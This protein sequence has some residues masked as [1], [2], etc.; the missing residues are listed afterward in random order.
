MKRWLM[1]MIVLAVGAGLVQAETWDGRWGLGLEAGVWKQIHGDHDYSNVDQYT[2]LKLRY[3]LDA[4]WTLDMGLQYGWTRP[5]VAIA[6]EDAGFSFDSGAGLYTRIWQPNLTGTYRL[7]TDGTW[8]PWVS[9]GAGVTRWDIRDLRGEESVGLWPDGV[10]RRV[11]DEDGVQVDGSGVNVTAILGLGTEIAA[12]HR[13]FDLGVRYNYLLGQTTDSVGLSSF[14]GADEVDANK[15]ILQGLVGVNYVFGN[16][17]KDGDG[18]PNDVDADPDHAEDF[19][20]YR[21]EDG[22]PDYDNDNDGILDV[23]DQCPDDAEDRDGFQDEDGCPDPDNDQDGIIDARD[24]APDQAEDMDGFQDED[25]VPDPDNDQDGVLDAMDKC[26]DTPR[27]VEVD[28]NGCPVVAEIREDLVL[29]GVNF[30]SG[31][32]QL[33]AESAMVLNKV[34]DSLKAWPNVR[35][36]VG[37]HTDSSG[38]SELNRTLSQKRAEAVRQ[39]LIGSGVDAGRITAVG[40]GEDKPIA[41]NSTKIGRAANRRVELKRIN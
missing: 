22:A 12:A 28:A 24:G 35:I 17:D 32:D 21:D 7:A 6:G 13:S 8:R 9:L 33:T 15:A 30:K 4:H 25:G 23:D 14:W 16:T 31:S 19:D 36:E 20:G 41:D 39:F 29:E 1:T 3:G 11:Y 37:G 2:A 40:Y 5:G 18:I 10:G 38:S 27:G 34:A 26:P